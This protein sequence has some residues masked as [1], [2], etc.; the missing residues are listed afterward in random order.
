MSKTVNSIPIL[1]LLSFT[2]TSGFA[3]VTLKY[4]SK[5]TGQPNTV[6]VSGVMVR[7]ESINSQGKNMSIYDNRKKTLTLINN[8]QKTYVVVDSAVIE[9]QAKRI[10]ERQKKIMEEVHQQLQTMSPEQRK[11]TEQKMAEQG[12]EGVKPK[13]APSRISTNRTGRLETLNGIPCV[14]YETFR[15]EEKIGEA[16]IAG[17]DALKI[18]HADYQTLQGLFTFLRSMTKQFAAGAYGAGNEMSMF[19]N[20]EG[21]PVKMANTQGDTIILE[22]VADKVLSAEQFSVPSDY[23]LADLSDPGKMDNS[24]GPTNSSPSGKHTQPPPGAT[25]GYG[26]SQGGYRRPHGQGGY[27]GSYPSP[28]PQGYRRY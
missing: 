19:D 16:C 10:H 23:T 20:V 3:D 6:M 4:S 12:V 18:S 24:Q 28:P 26:S 2:A 21:L 14:V 17:P 9:K 15:N 13:Q 25:G 7:T 27:D 8:E 22:D 5:T 11:L 1:L